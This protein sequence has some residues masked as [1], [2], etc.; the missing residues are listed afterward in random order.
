[1][2]TQKERGGEK[3]ATRGGGVYPEFRKKKNPGN[4]CR[5]EKPP[6]EKKGTRAFCGKRKRG[7]GF[8]RERKG[9]EVKINEQKKKRGDCEISYLTQK[10]GGK[11][12]KKGE[13]KKRKGKGARIPVPGEIRER[14]K[15]RKRKK[16]GRD[17]DSRA[18]AG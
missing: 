1:V 13:K 5:P 11:G 18:F 9:D 15:K 3:T 14:G 16:R 12:K 8:S 4:P 2:K 17:R 10:K 7:R 6:R